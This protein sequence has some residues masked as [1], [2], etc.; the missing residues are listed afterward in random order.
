MPCDKKCTSSFFLNEQMLCFLLLVAAIAA[1]IAA[2]CHCLQGVIDLSVIS[3]N[4]T[5]IR[6]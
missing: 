5:S 3:E 1:A 6:S 2:T 4:R